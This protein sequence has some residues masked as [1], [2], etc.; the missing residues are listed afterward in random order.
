[1]RKTGLLIAARRTLGD[2]RVTSISPEAR[3]EAAYKA[4]MQ[5]ALAALLIKSASG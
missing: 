3:L 2:A 1:M 5:S 4:L